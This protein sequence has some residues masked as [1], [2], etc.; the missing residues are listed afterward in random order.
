[1]RS[2]IRVF[3]GLIAAIGLLYRL[4]PTSPVSAH[5]ERER[6]REV[7]AGVH[8]DVS[9]PLPQLEAAEYIRMD[10]RATGYVGGL[11]PNGS[12]VPSAAHAAAALEA[13]ARITP[14][15]SQGDPDPSGGRIVLISVGMSNA[16]MEFQGFMD[17]GHGDPEINPS[18]TIT[19]GALSGQTADRWVNSEALAWTEL[20]ARL[21]RAEVTH[22]QVQVAW[23]KQT[24]LG[25]GDFPDKARELQA[26][27]GDI[28]RNLKSRFPNLRIA[29][30]S[31]RTRSFLYDRGISPEPVAFE[32]GFAVRWLIEE[33]INGEAELNFDPERGEVVAPVL[34][35]GPYLWVDGMN[36]R[37]DGL[38]WTPEDLTED[39]THPSPGGREKVAGLLMAFFKTDP[40]AAGWFLAARAQPSFEPPS[41]PTEAATARPTAAASPTAHPAAT[42]P[43]STD[44]D[45]PSSVATVAALLAI[46]LVGGYL[47]IRS[48][49]A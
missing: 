40:L 25:G 45:D 46:L 37:P 38:I 49:P 42:R 44:G 1:M 3:P 5:S 39:C 11:Y 23:V 22:L 43:A 19:N 9:L 18:L 4:G 16:Q 20:D 2:L 33:Q 8:R 29:F 12:N 31:S 35:W 26:A 34:V 28:V 48:R 41:T 17:L 30:L 27:L 24:L 6:A 14:L 15:N 47:W 32:T 7:C 21:E 13:A 36:P 10:G